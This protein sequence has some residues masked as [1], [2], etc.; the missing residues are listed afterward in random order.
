MARGDSVYKILEH[1]PEVYRDLSKRI[2][3]DALKDRLLKQRDVESEQVFQGKNLL[4]PDR[5]P[6]FF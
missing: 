2:G 6:Y 5:I 3:H 1:L 4:N